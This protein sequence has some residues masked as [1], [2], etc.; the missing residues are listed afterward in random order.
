MGEHDKEKE[1]VSVASKDNEP[2][3]TKSEN[4]GLFVMDEPEPELVKDDPKS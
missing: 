1:T 2:K 4:I 3:D